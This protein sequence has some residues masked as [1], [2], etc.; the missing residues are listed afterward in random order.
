MKP[1]WVLWTYIANY[2]RVQRVMARTA[3]DAHQQAT[4][5]FGADF[6]KKGTVYVFDHPPILCISKGEKLPPDDNGFWGPKQ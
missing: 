3:E 4:C 2:S 1:F 6:R 5:V